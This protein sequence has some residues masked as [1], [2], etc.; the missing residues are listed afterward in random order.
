MTPYL[1][2]QEPNPAQRSAA[3]QVARKRYAYIYDAR[4]NLSLLADEVPSQDRFSTRYIAERI[5]ATAELPVNLLAANAR[6]LFDPLDELVE[7]EDIFPVMPLPKVAKVYQTDHSF[8]EQRLS[9]VNPLVIRLLK[10]DDPRAQVLQ[11][12]PSAAADFEPLFKLAQELKAGNIYITDYTGADD[13]YAGPV[14]VEGGEHAKGRKY[15]PKVRAF[16]R[17]RHAGLGTK[18]ELVPIAIQLGKPLDGPVHTP[19][20]PPN[21]WLFAKFC[22][23]VADANHHE[24]STHLCRTHFA[25]EPFAIATARQLAANHPLNLLLRPHFRFMLAN[26]D[27]GRKRLINRSGPVD[28]LLAGTLDESLA[29]VADAYS[30]W[31]IDQFAFPTDIRNRGMDD[32]DRLP[33]YPY[34]DDGMLIWDAL[35]QFVT[36][37]LQ[38]FYP[39]AA[40]LLADP[41][42]QG[43]AKELAADRADGGANI[44]GMPGTIDKF[45]KLVEIIT[46]IIFTCG[47]LHSAVNYS[48]YDYMAFAANMPLAAYVDPAILNQPN[49]VF[50]EQTLLKLLPP[51]Y[52]AAGQLQILFILAAYRFDQLGDYDKTYRELYDK[53]FDQVFANTPVPKILG[54]FQL[55]LH[56]AEQRINE[57]NKRRVVP[58]NSMNP[59]GIINSIS[60]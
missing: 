12:I 57:R 4:T 36:G 8:A 46:T 56:R 51:Y 44:P 18:G 9:G 45:E 13:S 33:H 54:K 37:Y 58:Y 21:Q 39:D 11:R 42:L 48:Q 41:E 47:P 22:V 52:K 16:F 59:S 7:Y 5:A 10:A 26:N 6:S 24:M 49:P 3:L 35:Y 27:L 60:I 28:D 17:W 55:Q 30:T 29:L 32:R 43:W 1:P 20:S 19:F 25:M 2:H 53:K 38:S 34:R 14:L 50:T 31:S 40:S 15:L 23:Q